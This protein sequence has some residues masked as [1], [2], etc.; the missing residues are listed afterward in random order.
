MLRKIL[1]VSS[2]LMPL[3]TFAQGNGHAY[4]RIAHAPE[5]DGGNMVLGITLLGGI[6]SLVARRRKK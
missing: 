3:A 4:G 2:L 1:V 5:I 6:I